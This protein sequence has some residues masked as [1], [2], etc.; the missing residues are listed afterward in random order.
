MNSRNVIHPRAFLNVPHGETMS[1][2]VPQRS[3]LICLTHASSLILFHQLHRQI[4][5][6]V[7]DSYAVTLSMQITASIWLSSF[8]HVALCFLLFFG[9]VFFFFFFYRLLHSG[10]QLF[11]ESSLEVQ[12]GPADWL[13]NCSNGTFWWEESV[14]FS[15]VT[16]S[17]R[18]TAGAVTSA[19]LFISFHRLT[20]ED[21]LPTRLLWVPS[22]WTP[23]A[24]VC[25]T[26]DDTSDMHTDK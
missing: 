23:A 2:N 25:T 24:G 13:Q 15:S 3:D 19:F 20:F 7:W 6:L 5:T 1:E 18:Q 9:G 12:T 4:L 17:H 22:L 21:L 11:T 26:C 10:E 16:G 8:Q 14:V